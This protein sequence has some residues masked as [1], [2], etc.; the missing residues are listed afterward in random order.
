M[1][2]ILS[3]EAMTVPAAPY[4]S[5]TSPSMRFCT[6]VTGNLPFSSAA[7]MPLSLP[8]PSP[9]SMR[10]RLNRDASRRLVSSWFNRSVNAPRPSA[11]ARIALSEISICPYRFLSVVTN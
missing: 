8:L 6:S 1:L 7:P 9:Y 3:P 2:L 10:P 11:D 4:T 5:T